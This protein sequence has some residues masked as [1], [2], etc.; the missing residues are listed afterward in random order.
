MN[1][2][3]LAGAARNAWAISWLGAGIEAPHTTPTEV[4]IDEPHA[5]VERFAPSDDQRGNPVLLVT[6][7]AVP[8]TCWDLRPTQS[9]AAHLAGVAADT[10]GPGRPTY[11][12]DY[13]RITFADRRMGFE[14]W[15]SGIIP[16]AIRAISQ[17]HGGA[18]VHLVGWSHGG[19]M[20]ILTAAYDPGL[21]LA[22]ITAL[23]TPTDYKLNPVYAP[24]FWSHEQ[25][26]WHPL[27]LGPTIFGGTTEIGTRLG[28][29]WMAPAR[30]LTKPWMLVRNLH[31]PEVL[32]RI[33][34]TDGFIAS[35]PAY[36][37]RFFNQS[38]A[39]IVAER[40]LAEGRV[41]FSPEV[42]VEMENLTTPTLLIASSAD[43]LANPASVA[44]GV[45]AYPNADV[46][47]RKVKGLS[48]LGLIASPKAAQ[49]TWPLIDEQLARHDG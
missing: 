43:V 30:E 37:G 36:P 42:V 7:L 11:T 33:S 14:D 35:M 44:A 10:V 6:P 22:S 9:L 18:A 39:T 32:A 40:S 2:A 27:S 49:L 38:L 48:H 8:V 20:S 15:I 28:Y 24:V 16:S 13:G 34:A 31:R 26:G 1:L 19:T 12:I 4:L 41:Q 23:G 5:R 47:F 29:K 17:A 46:S 25:L 45:D 3:E 21:P